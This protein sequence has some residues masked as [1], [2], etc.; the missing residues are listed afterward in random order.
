MTVN[1]RMFELMLRKNI[2]MADLAKYLS[3][4]KTVISAWKSRGTNPP[5]EYVVQ[6]CELLDVSIEYFITGKEKGLAL[7]EQNLLD[8]YRNAAPGIQQATRKLLD[9]PETADQKAKGKLS[10]SKI[11]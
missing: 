11:G 7:E 6:I 10:H 9:L 5:I 1:E 3:V 4:N 2:R 8:A